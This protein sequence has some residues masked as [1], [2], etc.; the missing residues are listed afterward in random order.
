MT[1]RVIKA[2]RKVDVSRKISNNLVGEK[3][4]LG[5]RMMIGFVIIIGGVSIAACGHMWS[6]HWMFAYMIDGTGYLIHAIG[7]VPYIEWFITLGDDTA[8]EESKDDSFFK[9]DKNLFNNREN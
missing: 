3:H 7:A 9:D 1:S 6:I 4:S 2:L 8:Q 5:H